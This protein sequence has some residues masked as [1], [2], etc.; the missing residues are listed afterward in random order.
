M[1]LSQKGKSGQW[2]ILA[3]KAGV[4][5]LIDWS[6]TYDSALNVSVIS[7]DR[8]QGKSSKFYGVSYFLDG[9]IYIDNQ[10]VAEF[11]SATQTNYLYWGKTN[12]YADMRVQK[13]GLNVPFETENITHSAEGLKTVRISISLTGNTTRTGV[14]S[15]WIAELD[16]DIE[17]TKIYTGIEDLVSVPLRTVFFLDGKVVFPIYSRKAHGIVMLQN[18]AGVE[19]TVTGQFIRVDD[20][21]KTGQ[22]LK[23]Q[24]MPGKSVK[25]YGKNLVDYTQATGRNASQKVEI[26][27]D[28]VVWKAGGNYYF[29]IPL[30]LP[31]GVTV[32]FSCETEANSAGEYIQ[33][34]RLVYED[35]TTTNLIDPNG[36][37]PITTTKAV[38]AIY[39]YKDTPG[40]ALTQDLLV[41]NIQ[42]EIGSTITAYEAYKGIQTATADENGNVVG[43]TSVAPTMT[44]I[45]DEVAVECTYM[46][47]S[48]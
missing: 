15:G 13:G 43:L 17:L 40:T 38:K 34:V 8:I 26:V 21:A 29:T 16:Q 10:A 32:R 47:I 11:S 7:I 9:G 48:D 42:L 6:E 23:I 3:N 5:L 2:E 18:V 46:A 27:E 25:V 20:V 30:S 24:T 19:T 28:G 12:T 45:S 39:F 44:V 4:T 36:N 14:E 1:S 33:F 31:A 41:K 37:V 35:N 22:P